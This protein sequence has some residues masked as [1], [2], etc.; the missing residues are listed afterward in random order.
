MYVWI[1]YEVNKSGQ[2]Q[3]FKRGD[4]YLVIYIYFRI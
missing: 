4:K 3:R 2:Q 1:K